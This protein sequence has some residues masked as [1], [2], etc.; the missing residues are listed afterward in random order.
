M[1]FR[2]FIN[3]SGLKVLAM[4]RLGQCEYGIMLY[5]LNASASGLEELVTN[6]KELSSLIG[7]DESTLVEG[8]QSLQEKSLIIAKYCEKNQQHLDRQSIRIS[9]QWDITRWKLGFEEGVTAN[10]AVVFPFRQGKNLQLVSDPG[11]KLGTNAANISKSLPTWQRIYNSFIDGRE[12]D[13]KQIEKATQQSKMLVQTHPV[14]QVLL[15][16][17]HFGHRI[18]TL[19]LLASSWQ[20]YQDLFEQETQKV[21]LM[22]ARQ[23]H[24]EQDSKLREEVE[25]LLEKKEQLG[26]TE[27]EIEVLEIIFNHSHPRRQLFWAYQARGRYANLKEFFRENSK[28]MLPVSSSGAVIKKKP[29]QDS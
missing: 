23:K 3:E 9:V 4:A 15:M 1:A 21:D 25:S 2:S 26:L 17:R 29:H 27:E 10:D 14:D 13:K 6:R 8:I 19:S 5:L 22:D 7:Y 20:H 18:P 12:L 28:K 16:L 11:E 24:V